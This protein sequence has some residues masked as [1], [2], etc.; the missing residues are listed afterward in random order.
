VLSADG[1]SGPLIPTP[2]AMELGQHS[3]SY[4]AYMYS[5]N[6]RDIHIHREAYEYGQ[7]LIAMQWN[8]DVIEKNR[9]FLKLDPDNLIISALKKAE[10]EEAIIVRFFETKGEK[11][12]AELSLPSSIRFAKVVNLLEENESEMP[13]NDNKIIMAVNPFEIVTIKLLLN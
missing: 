13:V 9:Q 7:P 12:E 4:S 1:V 6:W 11:C 5:G 10:D 2:E 8:H 3:Y